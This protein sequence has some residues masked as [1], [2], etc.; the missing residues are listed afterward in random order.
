MC[1]DH[2]YWQVAEEG[3]DSSDPASVAAV[4]QLSERR[5]A[6]TELMVQLYNTEG[7]DKEVLDITTGSG[8]ADVEG[9]SRSGGNSVRDAIFPTMCNLLLVLGG[10]GA[11]QVG[12]QTSTKT[13]T[14]AKAA[15]ILQNFGCL[16]PPYAPKRCL[17][18]CP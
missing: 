4:Q 17:A 12:A 8:S 15:V 3:G 16:Y 7:A 13:P 6:L 10:S 9:E 11:W 18:S 5:T 1:G 14:S 2:C